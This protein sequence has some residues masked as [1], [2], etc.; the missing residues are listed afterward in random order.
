MV[1]LS[2]D[3]RIR[4]F[5]N[6]DFLNHTC[7]DETGFRQFRNMLLD[8][9]RQIETRSQFVKGIR[10]ETS[11]FCARKENICFVSSNFKLVCDIHG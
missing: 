7:L 10:L 8:W 2:S 4:N 5:V 1:I 6:T 3:E 11:D 9:K